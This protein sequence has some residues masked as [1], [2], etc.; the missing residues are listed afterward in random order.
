[1]IAIKA[2]TSFKE[3]RWER[4]YDF[5]KALF[6]LGGENSSNSAYAHNRKFMSLIPFFFE[7]F[8][9]KK[10]FVLRMEVYQKAELLKVEY[11]TTQGVGTHYMP[12]SRMIPITKYDYWASAGRFF[13]K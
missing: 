11:L 5:T 2:A 1:M 4:R 9:H 13:F 12:I 3:K 6:G 10:H 8:W 7:R